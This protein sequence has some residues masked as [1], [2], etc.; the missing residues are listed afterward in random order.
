MNWR[1]VT[2]GV[3][4]ALALASCGPEFTPYWKVDKLR[5]LA[6]KA[7]PVVAKHLEPVTLSALVYAPGDQEVEY[8]WSWCPIRPSAQNDYECYVDE[9]GLDA[10]LAEQ[11]GDDAGESLPEDFFYLGD[12]PTATFVNPL[13]EDEVRQLCRAIQR[14]I[15]EE[16]DDPE[17][18]RFLPGG[19]CA[20]G[21]EIALR[22]EVSTEEESLVASKRFTLWGGDE[23]YNKNPEFADFQIRPAN[24]ESLSTL[25]KWADWPVPEDTPHD[26]QWLSIPEDRALPIVTHTT[27]E[28]RALVDPESVLTYTP[29]PPIGQESEAPEPRKEALQFRYFTTGGNLS[30][31]SHLYSEDENTLEDA[32]IT[33]F[34]I[35]QWEVGEDCQIPTEEGCE[36][37]LWAA[38]RDSRLGVDWIGRRLLIEDS[39]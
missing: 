3:F 32:S 19:S 35:G 38:A 1:P 13:D 10:L 8:H 27:F 30:R 6:I 11:T 2:L 5:V 39:Q 4:A 21:Y 22:L 12:G 34:R 36:I 17:L 37:R 14:H 31:S 15:I 33:S 7:D 29:P 9:T 25:H 20:R 26:E 16:T 18:A 28:I 24:P 23:E